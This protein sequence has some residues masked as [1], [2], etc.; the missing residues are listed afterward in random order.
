[1]RSEPTRVAVDEVDRIKADYEFKIAKLEQQLRD[2]RVEET[3][4]DLEREVSDQKE[5]CFVDVFSLVFTKFFTEK[6][7]RSITPIEI[8]TTTSQI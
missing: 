1:M 6:K 4:N 7:I 8:R 5:V 3:I 2:T